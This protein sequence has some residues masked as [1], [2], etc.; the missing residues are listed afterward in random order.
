MTPITNDFTDPIL[1]MDYSKRCESLW[2]SLV[3]KIESVVVDSPDDMRSALQAKASSQ[4]GQYTSVH[5][6]DNNIAAT[7]AAAV[8]NPGG[9]YSEQ[10]TVKW[11][12]DFQETDGADDDDDDVE[13]VE[14]V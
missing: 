9:R 7:A 13:D 14:G 5:I 12:S 1:Q 6:D 4:A 2:G 8:G 11:K 3:P 10:E